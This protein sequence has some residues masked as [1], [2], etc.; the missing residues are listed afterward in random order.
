MN[1]VERLTDDVGPP[2]GE[3]LRPGREADRVDGLGEGDRP[4]QLEDGDVVLV[5]LGVVALVHPHGLEVKGHVGSLA[6]LVEI[7]LAHADLDVLHLKSENM[8]IV[9]YKYIY[10]KAASLSV[11]TYI[12]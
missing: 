8:E 7:I 4:V 3:L 9:V 12:R 5:G 11:H 2:V 1:E 6:L 10:S